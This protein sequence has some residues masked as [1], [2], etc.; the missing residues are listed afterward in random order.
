MAEKEK[1]TEKTSGLSLKMSVFLLIACPVIVIAL[2]SIA[3]VI[4]AGKIVPDDL[5]SFDEP[6]SYAVAVPETDEEAAELLTALIRTAQSSDTVK[7]NTDTRISYVKDTG[8]WDHKQLSLVSEAERGLLDGV[9]REVLAS[10][11]DDCDYGEKAPVFFDTALLEGGALQEARLNEENGLL[12]VKLALSSENS[13]KVFAVET[14]KIALAAAEAYK[15]IFTCGKAELSGAGV[16]LTAEINAVTGELK[17]LTAVCEPRAEFGKVTFIND[18]AELGE[19]RVDIETALS[20]E[21]NITFAGID[22]TKDI[23]YIDPDSYDTVPASA[24]IADGAEGVQLYYTSSDENICTVD[25]N[26]MI[27]AVNES[28]EPATVTVT[29]KYL[30]KEFTD[31]CLVYII[32]EAD[33]IDISE[34]KLSLKTGE[35]ALLSAEVTPKKATVKDVMWLSSDENICTVDENGAVKAVAAGEALITAVTVQGHF[36]EACHVTVTE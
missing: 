22:I 9:S 1:K 20:R 10:D 11:A 27:E 34:A 33:G 18:F 15:D 19:K 16:L 36:M 35:A 8:D 13:A 2:S 32:N 7:I 4:T 28:A 21:T 5:Y 26:G 17:K 31:T 24:N 6:V 25:E 29:L 30:G 23:L 14:E 3:I 12:Q